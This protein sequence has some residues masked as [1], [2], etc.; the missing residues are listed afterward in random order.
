VVEFMRE[1]VRAVQAL[2]ADCARASGLSQTDFLALVRVVAADG[3]TRAELK[4]IF[5]MTSSSI[6]ELAD[7][8]ERP[9]LIVRTRPPGDRRLVV[10]EPT[11]RGRRTVDRTLGPMLARMAQIVDSL[12]EDELSSVARFLHEVAQGVA[13]SA[14]K[15]TRSKR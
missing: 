15:R 12:A 6:T 8:L 1:L 13:E 10:L 11:R 4:R 14:P 9:G 2:L 5:G 3:M 7:R